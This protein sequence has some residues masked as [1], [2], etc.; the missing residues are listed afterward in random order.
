MRGMRRRQGLVAL[1]MVAFAA[2]CAERTQPLEAGMEQ[3]PALAAAA[4]G[5]AAAIQVASGSGQIGL[6]NEYLANPIVVRVVDAAGHRWPT[7]RS[8]GA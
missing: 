7:T 3:A 4:A 6:I 1:A 2:A 8:P 5:P